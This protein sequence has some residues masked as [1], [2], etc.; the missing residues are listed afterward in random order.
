MDS[1]RLTD[2]DRGYWSTMEQMDLALAHGARLAQLHR[3]A[4]RS[5]RDFLAEGDAFVSVSWGKDST[6][7]AALALAVRPDLLLVRVRMPPADNP[8]SD[9]VRDA[10]LRLYPTARYDEVVVPWPGMDGDAIDWRRAGV[11]SHQAFFREAHERHGPRC[12]LGIRASESGM[13][14]LSAAVHGTSTANRC[15]PLLH[16]HDTDVF[17]FLAALDLPVNATYAM[18]HGGLLE[19]GRLRVDIIGDEPGCEFGRREWEERYFGDVLEAMHAAPATAL[20]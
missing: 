8:C 20:R 17:A 7:L 2:A 9:D 14:E 1:P 4:E 15:R 3:R 10:F 6:V 11:R 18:T 12:M 13:R 16:W 19:R 5:V